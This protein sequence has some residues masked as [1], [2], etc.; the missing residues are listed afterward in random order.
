MRAEA[1][2]GVR[3]LAGGVPVSRSITPQVRVGDIA[4]VLASRGQGRPSEKIPQNQSSLPTP[5]HR[6]AS[7]QSLVPVEAGLMRSPSGNEEHQP[8]SNCRI[9]PPI[10]WP[11]L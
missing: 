4:G 1:F 8:E 10:L 7:N 5:G 2:D 9:Q 3:A 11:P 6:L